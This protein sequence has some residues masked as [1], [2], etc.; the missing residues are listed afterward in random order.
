MLSFFRSRLNLNNGWLNLSESQ[1]RSG[2]GVGVEVGD[3]FGSVAQGKHLAVS[4]AGVEVGKAAVFRRRYIYRYFSTLRYILGAMY[5]P[6]SVLYTHTHSLP[7]HKG[8]YKHFG[9]IAFKTKHIIVQQIINKS[10]LKRKRKDWREET[11][12]EG[13]SIVSRWRLLMIMANQSLLQAKPS[14]TVDKPNGNPIDDSYSAHRSSSEYLFVCPSPYAW[15]HM[16]NVNAA[17]G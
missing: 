12:R 5:R 4:W 1:L 8:D 16:E 3:L 11:V 10:S 14:K 17:S 6:I 2:T 9:L 7:M 13:T 15:L